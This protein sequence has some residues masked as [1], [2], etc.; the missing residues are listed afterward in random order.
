MLDEVHY[1]CNVVNVVHWRKG[2]CTENILILDSHQMCINHHFGMVYRVVSRQLSTA[3]VI[4]RLNC[5][6]RFQLSLW[7]LHICMRWSGTNAT[8]TYSQNSPDTFRSCTSWMSINVWHF[9]R[10]G[11]LS[12]VAKYSE[13]LNACMLHIRIAFTFTYDYNA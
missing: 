8:C 5:A 7:S 10:S 12:C 3:S 13:L 1:N 2:E 4:G 9:L 6:H 11:H